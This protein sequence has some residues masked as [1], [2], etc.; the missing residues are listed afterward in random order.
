M[1]KG[2]Q[3]YLTAMVVWTRKLRRKKCHCEDL[4][5]PAVNNYKGSGTYQKTVTFCIQAIE[6]EVKYQTMN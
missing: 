4:E 2:A 3:V 6:R 1:Q 5:K